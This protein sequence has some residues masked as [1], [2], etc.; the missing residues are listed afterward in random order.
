M[1]DFES[2]KLKRCPQCRGDH[3]KIQVGS[4]NS[5]FDRTVYILCQDCGAYW[6]ASTIEEA[7]KQWAVPQCLIDLERYAKNYLREVYFQKKTENSYA[8]GS[9][10][11]VEKFKGRALSGIIH[12]YY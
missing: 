5:I 9:L 2:K 11:D 10:E 4:C 6:T 7:E 8:V 3:M 1:A 12:D